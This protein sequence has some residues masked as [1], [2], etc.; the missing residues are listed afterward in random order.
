MNSVLNVQR[1]V[2]LRACR[3]QHWLSGKKEG[4]I[5]GGEKIKRKERKRGNVMKTRKKELNK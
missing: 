1:V 5:K 4:K 2:G 3:G